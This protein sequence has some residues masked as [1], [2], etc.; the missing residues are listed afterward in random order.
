MKKAMVIMLALLFLMSCQSVSN[1]VVPWDNLVQLDR[2]SD[3]MSNYFECQS[4]NSGNGGEGE[5]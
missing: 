2:C 1:P 3:D 5:E 4:L